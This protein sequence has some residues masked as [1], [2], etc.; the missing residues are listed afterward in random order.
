[1]PAREIVYHMNHLSS[2]NYPP[3][4]RFFNAFHHY[5]QI[6]FGLFYQKAPFLKSWFIHI[7]LELVFSS[8]GPPQS[9]DRLHLTWLSFV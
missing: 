3:S 6:L 4:P 1:M 9:P 2:P 7:K 8:N 5:F